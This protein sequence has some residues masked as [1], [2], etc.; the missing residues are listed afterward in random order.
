M[1]TSLFSSK[2][3]RSR[4]LGTSDELTAVAGES[5]AMTTN[6]SALRAPGVEQGD[7]RLRASGTGGVSTS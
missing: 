2:Q 7:L 5:T 6:D 4:S 3:R 1:T